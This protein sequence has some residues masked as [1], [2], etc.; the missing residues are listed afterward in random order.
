MPERDPGGWN[1][2]ASALGGM[3]IAG[4]ACVELTPGTV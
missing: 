1:L 3:A 2:K 4:A